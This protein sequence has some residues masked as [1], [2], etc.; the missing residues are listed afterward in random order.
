MIGAELGRQSTANVRNTGYFNDSS[1][2]FAVSATRQNV[3][4]PVTFRQSATAADNFN[5]V[6]ANSILHRSRSR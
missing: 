2:S 3:D 5:G 6:I 1:M 4:V